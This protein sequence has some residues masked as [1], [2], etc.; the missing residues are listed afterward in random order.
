VAEIKVLTSAMPA[1]YGHATAGALIVVKNPAPTLCTVRVA[2][3]SRAPP[4]CHRRFFQLAGSHHIDS[5]SDSSSYSTPTT[6]MLAGNFGAFTN[7]IYDPASTS[8]T[9]AAGNLSRVPFAGNIIPQ[10][11]FSTMW[12]TIAG[13]N[14]FKAPQAG[15]GSITNTG[16]GGGIVQ[17]R[18]RAVFQYHQSVPVDQNFS[19]KLRAS[20]SYSTGDQ[21]Q[22]QTNANITYAPYDQF[23]TLQYTVQQH[24]ALSVTYTLSP[25]LISETRMGIY[26]RT[27]NYKTLQFNQ[28]FTKITGTHAFKFGFSLLDN[29][30]AIGAPKPYSLRPHTPHTQYPP[31]RHR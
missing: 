1:E 8:G 26:R 15:A 31:R 11:R 27:G 21:H 17:V 14:P 22:P 12:K 13:N 3:S 9:F 7:Q 20:L 18:N 28:D 16:P 25:T 19:D 29:R 6:D 2:I 24:A 4:S 30:A 10:S 23:Q 5:S